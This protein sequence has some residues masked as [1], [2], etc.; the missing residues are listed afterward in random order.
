ML[1]FLYIYIL[2]LRIEATGFPTVNIVS[3]Y[4]GLKRV[5]VYLASGLSIHYM[6]TWSLIK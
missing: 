6:G 4:L 3:I 2:L 5:S 1:G